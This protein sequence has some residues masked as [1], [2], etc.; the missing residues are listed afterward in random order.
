MTARRTAAYIAKAVSEFET[1]DDLSDEETEETNDSVRNHVV[2]QDSSDSS[3]DDD[4]NYTADLRS[5][6]LPLQVKGRDGTT[7]NLITS[8]PHT[9]GR[10]AAHNVFT[11]SP[12]CR[13]SVAASISS[14]YDAWKHFIDEPMLR[15]IVN[16]TNDE[17]ARQGDDTF[18]LTLQELESFLAL[19]YA[20]GLYGKNHPVS[21]LWN[22][23]YGIQL[24]G[25]TMSRTRFLKILRYLRFDDKPKRQ[26]SS[27]KFIPIRNI[28]ENFVEN[29]RSK[30]TCGY[31]LT[32][33]EQLMP[34]KTRCG[35]ITYMPNKP[36][37]YG[38]KFWMLVDVDTKYVINLNPYLG[39]QERNERGDVPLAE[40]VVLKLIQPVRRHGYNICCDNFFT[41]L[42]LAE[43]LAMQHKISIVGTIRKNRRELS[44]SMTSAIKG[45][46]HESTFFWN[47]KSK[48]LF[49]KYQTKE[50]K[51]VCLLSTMHQNPDVREDDKRKPDMI[52]FY[53][54]NKV[55]IDIVDQMLRLYST[56][57]ASRR[58]PLAVWANIMDIAIINA[59]VVYNHVTRKS[60][61]RRSFLLEMIEH[62]RGMRQSSSANP[63][64]IQPRIDRRRRKCHKSHCQNATMTVCIACRRPTCGICAVENSKV[65]FVKC[66]DC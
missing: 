47:E 26:R 10:A 13:P 21:F 15:Q 23:D 9:V 61:S 39:K 41:S 42:P 22:S 55:G 4:D 66:E 3:S 43:K 19:Q 54:K 37:K 5:S 7:W 40:S 24:F 46:I 51:T 44:E 59:R 34:L 32:V 64:E 27:D 53:N 62:L 50:K 63:V 20:R 18:S 58:W 6:N 45:K 14:P 17:A 11:A 57:S 36:D 30:F 60:V 56:H 8:N 31:S 52:L 65:T 38:L 29:C 49:V 16:F 12:G 25:K 1:D 2:E 33:D 48:A 35:L 28:F